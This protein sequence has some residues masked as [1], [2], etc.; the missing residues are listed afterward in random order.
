V[1]VIVPIV[2]NR[3]GAEATAEIQATD[4]IGSMFPV[5]SNYLPS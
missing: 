3:D 1:R 2:P 4:F 5:L